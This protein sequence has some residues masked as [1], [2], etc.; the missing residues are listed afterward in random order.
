MSSQEDGPSLDAFVDALRETVRT[1]VQVL[2]SVVGPL[3]VQQP[4]Q[5]V[6]RR[7]QQL[8]DGLTRLLEEDLADG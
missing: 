2:S 1:V 5:D 3:R 7:L 6:E 8:R 4:V